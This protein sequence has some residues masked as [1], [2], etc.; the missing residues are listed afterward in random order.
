MNDYGTSLTGGKQ[1][2]SE[3]N[4]SKC[5]FVRHIFHMDGPGIEPCRGEAACNLLSYV[6]AL[7]VSLNDRYIKTLIYRFSEM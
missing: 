1:K 7:T 2:Y 6:A 3:K 4:L 5:H